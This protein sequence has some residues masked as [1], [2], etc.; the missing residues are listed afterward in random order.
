M[1][2]NMKNGKNT[3]KMTIIGLKPWDFAQFFK[4]I[5]LVHISAAGLTL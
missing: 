3:E 5:K 4:Y 1:G 2:K